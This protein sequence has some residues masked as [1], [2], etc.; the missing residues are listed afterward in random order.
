MAKRRPRCLTCGK[1]LVG[2]LKGG[3]IYCGP[4]CWPSRSR[5]EGSKVNLIELRAE[6]TAALERGESP[7]INTL[8][9][10]RRLDRILGNG[11]QS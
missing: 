10:L 1:P 7:M 9:L 2:S 6:V 8:A 4:S 5:P 3:R 11:K